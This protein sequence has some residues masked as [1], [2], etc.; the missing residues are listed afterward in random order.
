MHVEEFDL[1]RERLQRVAANVAKRFV[2][3]PVEVL[4]VV[5]LTIEAFED[6]LIDGMAIRNLD[7]WAAEVAR[8]TGR[9]IA[10][11]PRTVRFTTDP[12]SDL[13]KQSTWHLLAQ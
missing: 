11:R 7:G 5:E 6:A 13:A 9:L 3:D 8:R 4:E 1:R 10:N 12:A 2:R